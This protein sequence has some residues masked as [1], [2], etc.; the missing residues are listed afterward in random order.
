M[1]A[2]LERGASR[3]GRTKADF[4]R[5]VLA[6]GLKE[7]VCEANTTATANT[8]VP[9]GTRANSR[10]GF[11]L[12]PLLYM[13][14]LGG[15]GAAVM[16]SGYSQVL[17]SNAEI[18]ASNLARQQLTSAAQILSASS[19]LDA[20]TSTILQPPAAA[21]FSTITDTARLPASYAAVNGTGSPTTFGVVGASSG[22]RQLDPWGKYYIYCRWETA[23]ASP[24]LPSIMVISAGPDGILQ[25]KCGDTTAQGDDRINKLSV[26][27]AVNRANVWQVNSASQ[28]K[29]GVASNAVK[30]N[31]DGSM[32]AASLTLTT[33]LAIA[34]GGTG[35]GDVATA[36]T[37]LNV[38]S[39]TG[40]GANGIWGID[41]T[42]NAATAT[43][44]KTARQFSIAGSSGLTA[45]ATPF[46]GTA[47]VALSLAGTLA[48]AN[49]GT[50]ATT[51][52]AARTNLAVL[53]IANNLSDLAN[54]AT[55]RSN[56]G[57][58][59]LATQNANAVAIT[60]GSIAGTAFSGGT[61]S[62]AAIS[63][64]TINGTAITE[65]SMTISTAGVINAATVNNSTWN[66]GTISGA[67]ISGGSI[68]ASNVSG[69]TANYIPLWA[70][71]STLSS[72]AIYQNGSNIGIGN[73]NAAQKL[74]VTGYVA[75][76]S[77]NGEGGTIQLQGNNG[78]GIYIENINGDFRLVNSPWSAEIYRITQGGN[79]TVYGN[80]QV[81]GALTVNST[82]TLTGSAGVGGAPSGYKFT[83]YGDIYA[84]G[85]WL[86]VSGTQGLYFESYGGGW[87]MTDS[88]WIR[89][90]GGKPMFEAAGLDTG[91]ASGIN[92]G[93]G[94]GGGY[95]L[96]VCGTLKVTGAITF[97]DGTTQATAATGGGGGITASTSVSCT[98][99]PWNCTATCPA[100]YFRS[101][102]STFPAS[103]N[104]NDSGAMASGTDACY[105]ESPSYYSYATCTAYCVK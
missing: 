59:T 23:T 84:N 94:L 13:L 18:A 60:G 40:L 39:T 10:L 6:E 25:T 86:R 105:C 1:N 67:T 11:M 57:L 74:D 50:G 73:T 51:A 55:A 30:V 14:A 78:T 49:G 100:G 45:A 44:L 34:S 35:A 104:G 20:A 24:A 41:I 68:T 95:T 102:C 103:G 101:G 61:I 42:G 8:S 31:D 72:S 82:S 89:S 29:F 21:D 54:A 43:A 99:A 37:N 87:Q 66:G 3:A 90:Y 46:N 85:G 58:G 52:A 69:G 62:G 53:G 80:T 36:R 76:R 48:L 28:V 91:A 27:E 19:A 98:V 9:V 65:G 79:Q 96:R 47:D 93:G 81:N 5:M 4:I 7:L 26:G 32:Q 75:V 12:A 33:P 77:V 22:V 88:T 92:C 64:G 2:E 97:P 17:R 16:F 63:G 70:T 83:T 56:L 71:A 15:I 38:P